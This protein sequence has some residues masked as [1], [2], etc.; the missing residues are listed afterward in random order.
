MKYDNVKKLKSRIKEL[1]KENEFLQKGI[2]SREQ[3]HDI[4]CEQRDRAMALQQEL[5][6]LL[7]YMQ[8][9]EEALLKNDFSS[10]SKT[11]KRAINKFKMELTDGFAANH[12]ILQL[13]N[14]DENNDI[15][16]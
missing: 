5:V 14:N 7:L 4:A 9:V 13:N 15:A 6:F 1:Q 12:L 8:A 11:I 10:N 2:D 16:I 3:A